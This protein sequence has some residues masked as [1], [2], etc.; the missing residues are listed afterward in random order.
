MSLIRPQSEDDLELILHS[1]NKLAAAGELEDALAVC[2]WLIEDQRTAVA[3]LRQRAAVK[4]QF[5]D[6]D[7]AIRD[8]QKVVSISPYEPADFYFL[9]LQLLKVGSTVDAISAFT[10]AIGADVQAGSVYYTEGAFFFRAV[11][12]LK[13]CDYDEAIADLSSVGP[14]FKTHVANEGVRS[15]EQILAEVE[16]ALAQRSKFVFKLKK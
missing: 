11:C 1:S 16:G 3:G 2:N 7:G 12:R 9:G 10:S 8:L 13:M 15:R 4:L 5:S 14:G 6:V